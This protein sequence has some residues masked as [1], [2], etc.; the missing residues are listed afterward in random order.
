M[1][2][3]E[4]VSVC[5]LHEVC[6][7]RFTCGLTLTLNISLLCWI[8]LLFRKFV[9]RAHAK[10]QSSWPRAA[11]ALQLLVD[12][13]NV[14]VLQ[15]QFLPE[16]CSCCC[17]RG[18]NSPFPISTC[19]QRLTRQRK[20]KVSAAPP[21]SWARRSLRALVIFHSSLL[22]EGIFVFLLVC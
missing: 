3:C 5:S 10:P 1:R 14:A 15:Q 6:V 8:F 17:C 4:S 19:S 12:N 21:P 18:E 22:T 7:S 13:D 9:S 11:D 2:R 16:C 20:T